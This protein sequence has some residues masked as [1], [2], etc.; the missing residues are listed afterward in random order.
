MIQQTISYELRLAASPLSKPV[1]PIALGYNDTG[2]T[3]LREVMALAIRYGLLGIPPAYFSAAAS[4]PSGK[5]IWQA[6]DTLAVCHSCEN[7]TANYP[8]GP[9]GGTTFCNAAPSS[10]FVGPSICISPSIYTAPPTTRF[11]NASIYYFEPILSETDQ[12][13]KTKFKQQTRVTYDCS[14][15][16]CIRSFSSAIAT[17]GVFVEERRNSSNLKGRVRIVS[18]GLPAGGNNEQNFTVDES[19]NYHV[20]K[21][22]RQALELFYFGND[23]NHILAD[24]T[25]VF[26]NISNT[27]SAQLR[28]V[29]F[30]LSS[31]SPSSSNSGP[32]TTT[33]RT[34][35]FFATG[36]AFYR[37]PALVVLW[38]WL[39][40]PVF[41][42]FA[43]AFFLFL[44]IFTARNP[45]WKDSLWPLCLWARPRQVAIRIGQG[46]SRGQ[47][48]GQCQGQGQG[49]V[50]GLED[51]K[52]VAGVTVRLQ[53]DGRG[54]WGFTLG[55]QERGEVGG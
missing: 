7:V 26:K 28:T 30:S 53:R 31:S 5:C 43:T 15:S 14:L 41:L 45:V 17:G 12:M 10:P 9:S 40:F 20:F 29:P 22:V 46:Q 8:Q 35:T 24:P 33:T 4:C 36:T 18:D 16:W 34:T 49:W 32:N 3:E 52:R 50:Y 55:R 13:G 25:P 6:Y 54:G 2:S 37:E 11:F 27:I 39:I 42:L 21:S 38:A 44:V 23:K 51:M 48:Q 1:L 19:S 47:D